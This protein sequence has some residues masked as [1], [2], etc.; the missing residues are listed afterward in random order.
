M[1][2]KKALLG[3]DRKQVDATIDRLTLDAMDSARS[4]DRLRD[5]LDE[6]RRMVADLRRDYDQVSQALV[7]AHKI[8]AEVREAAERDAREIVLEARKRADD[9]LRDADL[10]LKGLEREIGM[11]DKHRMDAEE[12][13]ATFVSAIVRAYECRRA[14]PAPSLPA[15]S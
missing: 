7:S 9:T 2:F 13:Y 11:L 6:Q 15:A 12:A 8:A 10:S 4:A 14:T 3:Y 5:E 1:P